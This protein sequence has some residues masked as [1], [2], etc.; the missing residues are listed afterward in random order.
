MSTSVDVV[1]LRQFF[2][3][4]NH[5]GI[6]EFIDFLA[7]PDQSSLFQVGSGTIN[8][9]DGPDDFTGS[10]YL[11]SGDGSIRPLQSMELLTHT[12]DRLPEKKRER[13]DL[14]LGLLT[15]FLSYRPPPNQ[16]AAR[17]T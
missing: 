10:F 5:L 11:G 8:W 17:H 2:E 12:F 4:R 14:I 3:S 9:G 16:Q 13:V 15:P 7:H 1:A 6:V